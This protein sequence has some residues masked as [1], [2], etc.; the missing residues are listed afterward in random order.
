MSRVRP[1]GSQGS[2][3]SVDSIITYQTPKRFYH[4]SATLFGRHLCATGGRNETGQLSCETQMKPAA[5]LSLPPEASYTRF[6]LGV[7]SDAVCTW[8]SEDGLGHST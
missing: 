3:W 2:G 6:L 8:D 7:R 4:R 5:K 1:A